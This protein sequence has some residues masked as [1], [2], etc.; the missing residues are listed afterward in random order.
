MDGYWR[1]TISGREIFF[2]SRMVTYEELRQALI[3]VCPPPMDGDDHPIYGE[4][5]L[6]SSPDEPLDREIDLKFENDFVLKL[7]A[8]QANLPDE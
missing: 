7:H 5:R 3:L 2:E 4:P 1:A 8:K 6:K